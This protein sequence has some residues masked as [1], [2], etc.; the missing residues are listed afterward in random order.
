MNGMFS[1]ASSFDHPLDSWDVSKVTDMNGMFSYASSFDHPLDS[2]DV[3]KV[4]D[5]NG[6][7]SGADSFDH[8]LDSWD[9]SKVTDMNGMFSGARSF[10][11]NLGKWYVVPADAAYDVSGT[12]LDITAIS[13]QNSFLDRHVPT[14]GIGT[15]D[16]SGLFDMTGDILTFKSA[17]SIGKYEVNVTAS[18]PNVFENGNN[19]RMFNVTA[20]G[21]PAGAFVTT[22]GVTDDDLV[23]EIPV[24]GTTGN[25]AVDWGDRSTTTH[26]AGAAH[27]Y[28]VAGSYTV[29]ISGDF[30]RI[31][32][33]GNQDNAPQL[34]SIDQWGDIEWSSMAN[35]FRGASNMTYGATDAPDLSGVT[36]MSHMFSGASSFNGDISGWDASSVEDMSR[37]LLTC[38]PAPP[39]LTATS[40]DG[41]S[42]RWKTCPAC[43]TA[44]PPLT[45]PSALGMSH[46]PPTCYPC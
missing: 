42:R 28:G 35:A 38:S 21:S 6:M 29:N 7:F 34:L 40:R 37:R 43:S 44:P 5:M 15:G 45:S 12:S 22:W 23:V 26:T 10:E 32:L 33:N 2:W 13:A 1:Y 24:G 9:V 8:P 18:G 17:P 39:H 20:A 4:T 16:D 31:L 3:S 36:D 27:T 41:T 19:W 25:Y 30:K 11:Q 46:L 14:Y